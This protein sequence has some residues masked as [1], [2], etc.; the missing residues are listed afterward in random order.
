[1]S[2]LMEKLKVAKAIMDKHETIGKSNNENGGKKTPVLEEYN[3]P[4]VR[5][6]LPDDVSMDEPQVVNKSNLPTKDRVLQ[7]KL[8]DEIKRLMIEH[9]ING[10]E[11]IQTKSVLSDELV[12]RANKLMGNNKPQIQERKASTPVTNNSELRSMLKEVLT[13][14]LTENGLLYEGSK[15]T[16]DM[17][18]LRVGQH[19]FE[20]KVTNIKKIKPHNKI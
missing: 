17:L 16:S 15:K 11:P 14:I 3:Q 4:N 2:D 1:M 7:S 19:V 13:E 18:S 9:P 10:P 5:Y 8:P 20:G 12:D 6:N